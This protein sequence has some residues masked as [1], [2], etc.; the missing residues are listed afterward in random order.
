MED[1]LSNYLTPTR[2]ILLGDGDFVSFA[3]WGYWE[4]AVPGVAQQYKVDGRHRD[5]ANFAF[6]DGHVGRFSKLQKGEWLWDWWVWVPTYD[7]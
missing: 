7:E 5:G 6:A 2:K 1:R 4:W 3:M